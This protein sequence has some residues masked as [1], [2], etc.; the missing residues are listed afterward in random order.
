VQSLAKGL[1][2]TNKVR[3]TD[4]QTDAPTETEFKEENVRTLG[5]GKF[6]KNVKTKKKKIPKI[7]NVTNFEKSQTLYK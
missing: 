3:E 6:F 1:S 2:D 5:L 7:R 4:K